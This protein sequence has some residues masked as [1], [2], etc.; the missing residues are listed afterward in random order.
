MAAVSPLTFYH[1]PNT[2]STATRILLEALGAPYDLQVLDLKKSEQR[3]PDYL[4]VNP[5]GKVPAIVHRGQ[6]VTETVAIF[7]YLAD[8]F[9]AAKLA[10]RGDDPLRGPYLRWMVYYA[11]CFEPAVADRALK[12]E[13]GSP[14]LLGY[15]DFDTMLKTLTDEIEKAPC[16][17]GETYTAADILWATGLW[18]TMAF[19]IVPKLPVIEDYVARIRQR[20]EFARVETL[21]AELAAK[22]AG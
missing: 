22:L 19:G 14:S 7:L 8:A 5:M 18:W 6:L 20:P 3:Q 10:P 15:G 9:P 21:D 13:P 1:S 16:L 17:L 11:A 2:R 12:R 4:A